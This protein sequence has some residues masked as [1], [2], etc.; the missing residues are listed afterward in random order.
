MAHT[1][2][3]GAVKANVKQAANDA[4]NMF[5]IATIYGVGQRD[6]ESDHPK[7]LALDF[8]VPG[9]SAKGDQ[10]AQYFL[11][12]A[13]KYGVHYI[14]WK[15]QI[16]NITERPSE[17]WRSMPDR[18]GV[19][20]N[21]YDHVHVSF[22][23]VSVGAGASILPTVNIPNPLNGLGSLA[24]AAKWITDTHNWYRVA[25]FVLGMNLVLLALILIMAGGKS[26]ATDIGKAVGK[27]TK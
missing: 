25:L 23:N 22:N 20:A 4:G 2:V 8:M 21:H 12:N 10:V 17:G 15:Q 26:A 3:L 7:G 9:N 16:N 27:V 19:T 14:I 5:D 13:T 11:S 6:G 18:G 1:Y 24:D